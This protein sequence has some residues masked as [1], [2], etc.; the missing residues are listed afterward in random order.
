[1]WSSFKKKIEGFIN[2]SSIT[3]SSSFSVFFF[4]ALF[5][6]WCLCFCFCFCFRF[7]FVFVLLSLLFFASLLQLDARAPSPSAFCAPGSFNN[8]LSLSLLLLCAV[9]QEGIGHG[10]LG[11]SGWVV[12]LESLRYHAGGASAV[13]VDSVLAPQATQYG[14]GFIQEK[15]H[16][17][18][19]SPVAREQN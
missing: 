14:C 2:L 15:S 10:S 3:I 12:G 8:Q 7:V 1:M 18:A 19:Q 16:A 13:K 11:S 5:I 17:E 6:Y 4:L 9:D